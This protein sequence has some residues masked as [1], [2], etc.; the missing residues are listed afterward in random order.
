MAKTKVKMSR[1][2]RAK[3]SRAVKRRWAAYRKAKKAGR[4]VSAGRRGPGRPK[5]RPGRKPGRR[6]ARA[7]RGMNQDLSGLAMAELIST[8]RRIDQE[9]ADRLV[10]GNVQ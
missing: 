8:R 3:I 7:G 1:A 5:G 9:L 4:V 6:R 2:A 10:R